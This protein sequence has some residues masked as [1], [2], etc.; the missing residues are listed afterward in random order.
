LLQSGRDGANPCIEG[1]ESQFA[2]DIIPF[3]KAQR[4]PIRTQRRVAA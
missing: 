1:G 4:H 3:E 2:G